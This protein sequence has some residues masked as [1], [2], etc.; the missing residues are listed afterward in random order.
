M[1][2][3]AITEVPLLPDRRVKKRGRYRPLWKWASV[4]V[5]VTVT[6]LLVILPASRK[7]SESPQVQ[8]SSFT[9]SFDKVDY[10]DLEKPVPRQERRYGKT[11]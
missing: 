6:A 10:N 2:S 8:A 4:V 7:K 9:V 1:P 11:R 5:L 3:F